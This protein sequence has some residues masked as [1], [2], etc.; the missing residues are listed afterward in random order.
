M[1][2]FVNIA[3][4]SVLIF[5]LFSCSKTEK[6][7]KLQT[8][9]IPGTNVSFQYPVYKRLA[10]GDML[11]TYKGDDKIAF[12]AFTWKLSWPEW[13]TEKLIKQSGR[14]NP[15][16][17][18]NMLNLIGNNK[19][20][21]LLPEEILNFYCT[22]R[23]FYY[24]DKIIGEE[25]YELDAYNLV[26]KLRFIIE[27]K[28]VNISVWYN[29]YYEYPKLDEIIKAYPDLF[30]CTNEVWEHYEKKPEVTADQL[31]HILFEEPYEKLPEV[32]LC[33]RKTVESIRN[34]LVIPEYDKVLEKNPEQK[35]HVYPLSRV[36]STNEY[37]DVSELSEREIELKD[38][39]EAHRNS[40]WKVI[41]DFDLDGLIQVK[42]VLQV[43]DEI[44]FTDRTINYNGNIVEYEKIKKYF[45]SD[46]DLRMETWGS[47]SRSL[48]FEDFETDVDSLYNEWFIIKRKSEDD[49]L[50][51]IPSG[52]YYIDYDLAVVECGG[53][54]SLMKR[55]K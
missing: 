23:K 33:F 3:I 9:T 32:L 12:A 38:F 15:T 54:Y 1:K 40:T 35:E 42:K 18:Q 53:Y 5:G 43:G 50:E 29:K 52:F 28:I 39:I 27:N 26:Y 6:F 4:F 47:G 30:Y 37:F 36:S 2:K 44:K 49:D 17:K 41:K 45:Y 11:N 13:F 10:Y 22:K 21:I 25:F 46:D 14:E 55:I 24:H 31:N 20:T 16:D 8:Y 7:N 51:L 34:S 48:S 19:N